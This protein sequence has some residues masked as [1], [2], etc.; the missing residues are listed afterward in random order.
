MRD[1]LPAVAMLAASIGIVA[2]SADRLSAA[3]KP[4]FV[5]ILADDLGYSDLGCYGSAFHETPNL[6][7]LASEGLRFTQAYTAGAVCSPTRSSLM[8]GKY[9]VRTGITDYIPGLSSEGRKLQAPRTKT[10][11]ALEEFTLGEALRESGYQT[12]YAGKWHL[13]G[14][15]FEPS[16]QGFD[17]YVS[18][19][20][21]GNYGQD[22]RFGERLTSAAS[23]FLK[24]RDGTK[25]FLMY[26]AFH[27]PHTPILE[28]PTQIEHFRKKAESVNLPAGPLEVNE[29]HGKTRIVQNNPAYGSEIAGLDDWVGRVLKDLDQR[30][31]AQNTVVIFFSDNGGLSTR[32]M[33]G[34]TSNQPLR[35]GKGWLYEGGIRVPLIVRAPGLTKPRS[36]CDVPVISTDIYPTLLEL[37]GLPLR[38]Q[39]HVDGVSFAALLSNTA[40]PGPRVFY[41]HYPHYHGSTWAPGSALRDGDWKLIDFL[42]EG[43]SE[44]YNLRDDPG[45]RQNLAERNPEMHRAL[46]SKLDAW[47]SSTGAIIPPP[48]D[49]SPTKAWKA[50]RKAKKN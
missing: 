17:F 38:P 10:E 4:N 13:G 23:D 25:P 44:L 5:F 48:A 11:L 45:E 50:K 46:L 12:F 6:D 28:Y 19:R 35:A 20:D 14:K 8:T 7:R 40:A 29:R 26:L 21:L 36:T 33:P 9:P 42:E 3:E 27:E 47:R 43:Q 18:D 31:L 30:G 32:P 16:D 49:V 34:P 24:K 37:A 41:W 22:W 39:Q 1:L 15:G 2:V